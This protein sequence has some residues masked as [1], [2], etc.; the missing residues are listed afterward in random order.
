MVTRIQGR[1]L[2]THNLTGRELHTS[3]IIT[4]KNPIDTPGVL[5]LT[6]KYC[7]L[8]PS[9]GM[10]RIRVLVVHV[11]SREIGIYEPVFS[12]EVMYRSARV[13][14]EIAGQN[15]RRVVALKPEDTL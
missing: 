9:V 4:H 10:V 8:C 11:P 13:T 12:Q 6:A 1:F 2:V 7:R 15:N 14:I 5:S 3:W